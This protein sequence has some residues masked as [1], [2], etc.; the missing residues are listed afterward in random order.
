MKKA[1]EK[2]C[3]YA[4]ELTELYDGSKVMF[5]YMNGYNIKYSYKVYNEDSV[6]LIIPY[7]S[8]NRDIIKDKLKNAI[9]D[10][11]SEHYDLRLEHN[12]NTYGADLS[13]GQLEVAISIRPKNKPKF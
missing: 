9:K 10:F 2:I 12:L 3:N 4:Y 1:I 5:K 7:G 13:F 11:K 6:H 8:K